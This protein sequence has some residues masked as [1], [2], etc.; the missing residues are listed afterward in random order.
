MNPLDYAIV[1]GFNNY[2]NFR[3]LTGA[4]GDALRLQEWLLSPNGGGLPEKNCAFIP[5]KEV[6]IDGKKKGLPQYED[7]YEPIERI[8]ALAK[9]SP[10]RRLYFYFSGHGIGITFDDGGLCLPGWSEN[11][12]A[13]GLSIREHK[14]YFEGL[15]IFKELVFFFDCCRLK[16]TQNLEKFL[17]PINR[18]FSPKTGGHKIF[19]AYGA[20]FNEPSFESQ[21][22]PGLSIEK[23]GNFTSALIEALKEKKAIKNNAITS[24]DLK[25]YLS[26]R[27]SEI[28]KANNQVQ[29]ADFGVTDD[30]IIFF[31]DTIPPPIIIDI[32][33][34]SYTDGKVV[35]VNSSNEL[36]SEIASPFP[37]P[38]KVVLPAYGAYALKHNDVSE[39]Q[40]II[41]VFPATP[42]N[43]EY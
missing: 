24:A 32:K 19:V 9:A 18:Q 2:P 6:V 39:T 3:N 34:S 38:W 12:S 41:A 1:I 15:Q 7:I 35:V 30:D 36:I 11:R 17:P 40:K 20:E 37:Q 43:Y 31:Q 10:P 4:E 25:T 27:V 5:S 22:N 26:T 21:A 14:L 42:L 16:F 13:L 29:R 8:I 33:I 28:A 23:M